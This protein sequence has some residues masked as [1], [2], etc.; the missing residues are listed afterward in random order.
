MLFALVGLGFSGGSLLL[1]RALSPSEFGITALWLAVFYVS[2]ALAP[3]GADGVVN[4]RHIRPG[5]HLV[6]RTIFTSAVTGTV[7]VFVAALL[8][9]FSTPFLLLL[10]V[11]IIGGGM[12]TM[13]AAQ[14][15]ARHQF[16]RAMAI[17][18][19]SNLLLVAAGIVAILQPN[20]GA[21]L[22]VA[23]LTAGTLLVAGVGWV[24]L[25]DTTR[26]EPEDASEPFVWREALSYFTAASAAAVLPQ[27]ERLVIPRVLSLEDLA[28]FGVLAAVVIAPFRMVQAGV[29]YTLFP[30]LTRA[31]TVGE[32]R[33]LVGSELR[34]VLP[35]LLLA[36]LAVWYLA[37]WVTELFVDDKYELDAAL[38]LAGLIAGAAK[39]AESFGRALVS[40][41]GTNRELALYGTASWAAL[42]AAVLGARLGMPWGVP[43]VIIGTTG[44][45]SIRWL[46]A[47][48]LGLRHLTRER[49]AGSPGQPASLG[50]PAEREAPGPF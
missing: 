15:Q 17:W 16:T 3:W 24:N 14:F 32:R 48:G 33:R 28:V 26:G 21:L 50:G 22:P 5:W 20:A 30:R 36:G 49:L 42:A 7:A 25:R 41:L 11:S 19:G 35:G 47:L 46:L 8:Y 45:L 34:I 10:Q 23:V 6:L 40:A 4:R 2:G 44:G 13:A 12:S 37:P 27:I 39:L 31:E 29:A 18:R 1:A 9:P 43:G 38:L